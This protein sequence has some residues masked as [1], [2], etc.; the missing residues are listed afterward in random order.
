LL[1]AAIAS[2]LATLCNPYGVSMLGFL[3]E[4]VRPGRTDILEWQPATRVPIVGL[5]LWLV[6]TAMAM[7]Q[8]WSQRRRPAPAALLVVLLLSVGS[9]RV[10]RLVGFYAL[11][12][13]FLIVPSV[14]TPAVDDDEHATV[15]PVAVWARHA[16]VSAALVL[17]AVAIFGRTLAM[18]AEWLPE[19]EATVFVKTHD[20]SGRMLTWFDYGEF[21]IWHFA[22]ALR[23][24]MDGRRETVYSDD[25]RDRHFRI[26]T[27]APDALDQV[28]RL[29]PDY[30]WLPAR[31]PVVGRL[32]AAGWHAVFTGSRSVILSRRTPA[33]IATAFELPPLQRAFPGP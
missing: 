2:A 4:T 21:A 20:I 24:S 8:M 3:A 29:D 15:N 26:Y 18:D 12:V 32:E 30:V 1:A 9:F 31:F 11:A 33:A 5:L 28:A 14:R 13:A 17:V 27:N 7:W 22:P 16:L 6:P 10:I 25:V 23:V 19:R